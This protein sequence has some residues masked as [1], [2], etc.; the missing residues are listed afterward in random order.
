MLKHRSTRITISRFWTMSTIESLHVGMGR[1]CQQKVDGN[2][3]SHTGRVLRVEYWQNRGIRLGDNDKGIAGW[4]RPP[5][6]AVETAILQCN[7]LISA[8]NPSR[9][10]ASDKALKTRAGTHTAFPDGRRLDE[11]EQLR[12]PGGVSAGAI[13]C[14]V[15]CA[16]RL[17]FCNF[18]VVGGSFTVVRSAGH[19]TSPWWENVP[20]VTIV[21]GSSARMR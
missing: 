3:V 21:R 18:R 10:H 9:S 1:T 20:T 17:V 12:S 7:H 8:V 4:P 15:G 2:F 16:D 11:S 19:S 6:V 5:A 13:H 14:T